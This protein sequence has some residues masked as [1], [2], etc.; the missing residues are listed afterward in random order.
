[1]H[2]KKQPKILF[3]FFFFVITVQTLLFAP[4]YSNAETNN[5]NITSNWLSVQT[6]GF[7]DLTPNAYENDLFT[8]IGGYDL[9]EFENLGLLFEDTTNEVLV[10]GGKIT[11][12]FEMSAFTSVDYEDMYP[13]ININSEYTDWFFGLNRYQLLGA[14]YT[15]Y[16]FSYRE[17]DYGDIRVPH[18]YNG[19]IPLTVSMKDLTM[20]SGS[21]TIGGTTLPTPEYIFDLMTVNTEI[22]R[23]EVVGEYEDRFID[24]NNIDEGKVN[25]AV[26]TDLLPE[27]SAVVDWYQNAGIGWRAGSIENGQTLQQYVV[28]GDGSTYQ[29]PD[30]NIDK[31]FTFNVGMELKP[32]AYEYVQYNDI[33]KG[34]I[35]LWEWGLFAGNIDTVYGPATERLRRVVAIHPVNHMI[36]WDYSVEVLVYA[37][38][39]S[40][41]EITETVLNNPY[42]QYGDFV[43]DTSITG[44]YNVEVPIV[45][46]SFLLDWIDWIIWIVVIVIIV[47]IIWIVFKSITVG[48]I[49][50]K[51]KDK[52][53]QTINVNIKK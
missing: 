52:N 30:P 47:I 1:M 17:I 15:S 39:P 13:H 10:Y 16:D 25:F 20:T 27:Q 32:S 19:Y 8:E 44:E 9:I 22:V 49:L 45:V 2:L 38:I 12:G 33:T 48:A 11:F 40:T 35:I 26:L 21:M 41:A 31:E 18:D 5:L 7:V 29:N 53:T 6:T 37:T 36:H 34:S 3:F 43:W 50:K 4:I 23:S 24:I 28:Y 14:Y 42:L 51:K 46:G